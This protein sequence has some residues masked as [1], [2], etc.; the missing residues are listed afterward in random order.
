MTR[1]LLTL[2]MVFSLCVPGLAGTETDQTLRLKIGNP[3]Y[4]DQTLRIEEGKIYSAEQGKEVSFEEMIKAMEEARFVY[5]GESHTSLPMHHIQFEIAQALYRQDLDLCIGLEMFNVNWQEELNNWSL[6]LLT[7]DEFIDQAKWYENWNYNF[8]YY[9]KIFDL[10][11]KHNI[12]LYALNAPREIIHKIRMKGWEALTDQEKKRVPKPGL[13]HKEHRQLIKSIFDEE[14]IPEAMKGRE[15]MMFESLYRAQSAWDEVMAKN[16]VRA[17]R[18]EKSR[19][20][21]LAGSGHLLYN[22]GINRRVS[23]RAA[24]PYK[25]VICV[26]VPQGKNTME[27]SRSLADFIWGIPE[28]ERPAYPKPGIALKKVEGLD[29]LVIKRDPV[30]GAA[31]GQNFKKGD[32]ILSVDGKRYTS[33]NNLRKC[34]SRFTWGEEVSFTL[35]R[36]ARKIQTQLSFQ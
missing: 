33:I 32:I 27:V 6:G 23:E 3:S 22:L 16:A 25:T 26:M 31:K 13:S 4:K 29:N 5:V 28:E 2:I 18:V 34:L 10:A 1:K 36:S 8:H 7:E 30:S 20:L 11:K 21:V 12:P 14:E 9:K 24:F 19:V 17:A 15:Q 35:L